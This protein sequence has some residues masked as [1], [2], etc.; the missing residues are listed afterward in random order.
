MDIL[1]FIIFIGIVLVVFYLFSR[2]LFIDYF[3]KPG[4]LEESKKFKLLQKKE[5]DEKVN[6]K[7]EN[8]PN[9]VM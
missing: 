9:D 2:K 3:N 4:D 8:K 7:E 6:L 5:A 1:I